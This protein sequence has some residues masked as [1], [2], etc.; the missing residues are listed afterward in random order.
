MQWGREHEATGVLAGVHATAHVEAN[1]HNR[2]IET[3]KT[4]HRP[5]AIAIISTGSTLPTF[6]CPPEC[7]CNRLHA[8]PS[9]LLIHKLLPW[10]GASPDALVMDPKGMRPDGSP[11]IFGALE[12]KC[13]Y[14]VANLRK[15][16]MPKDWYANE[17]TGKSAIVPVCQQKTAVYRQIQW[18]LAI[19]RS[20]K[21]PEILSML[22]MRWVFSALGGFCTTRRGSDSDY[23]LYAGA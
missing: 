3:M 19:L 13:P 23:V 12:I 17:K 9:G 18:I 1:M 6:S 21:A 15:D 22:G 4:V 7:S 5:T 14:K 16:G 10:L 11:S 20:W 2:T 8:K